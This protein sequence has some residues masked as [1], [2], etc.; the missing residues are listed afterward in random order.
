MSV[1]ALSAVHRIGRIGQDAISFVTPEDQ[2]L[3][4]QTISN[5]VP[6][7]IAGH[8][9]DVNARDEHTV[10]PWLAGK[11]DYSPPVVDL[12]EAGYTLIGDRIGYAGPVSRRS[13]FVPAWKSLDQPIRLAEGIINRHA[14]YNN[15]EGRLFMKWHGFFSFIV[16][17]SLLLVFPELSLVHCGRADNMDN[18]EAKDSREE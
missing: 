4:A 7:L 3:V 8:S 12:S 2:E 5:Y 15:Y 13:D 10:K 11:L 1:Y 6:S 16:P 9:A 14:R 17:P 18:C